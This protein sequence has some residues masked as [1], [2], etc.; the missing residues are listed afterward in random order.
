[1]LQNSVQSRSVSVGPGSVWTEVGHLCIEGGVIGRQQSFCGFPYLS[2]MRWYQMKKYIYQIMCEIA[3]WIPLLSSR[4][5]CLFL[6]PHKIKAVLRKKYVRK[7]KNSF[8]MPLFCS[9]IL[10]SSSPTR[11]RPPI[12]SALIVSLLSFTMTG[13]ISNMHPTRRQPHN[14]GSRGEGI[15]L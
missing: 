14:Q 12:R 4:E 5:T 7:L 8:L 6:H 13:K 10:L 11:N 9:T 2:A 3:P 1:M 15:A